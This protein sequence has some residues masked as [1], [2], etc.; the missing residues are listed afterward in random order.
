MDVTGAFLHS[1]LK[2]E[3]YMEAPH[4][5]YRNNRICRVLKSIYGL[6]QAPHLWFKSISGALHKLGFNSLQ[7]DACCFT[8]KAQDVFVMVFV[9]DIQITGSN[10]R[11]IQI[12]QT[13]LRSEFIMKDVEP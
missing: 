3:I 10:D 13:G 12:L 9:D 5:F 11:D 8:N 2:N 7:S 6:K 1:S 4:G